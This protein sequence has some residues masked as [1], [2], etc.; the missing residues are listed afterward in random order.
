MLKPPQLSSRAALLLLILFVV[1]ATTALAQSPITVAQVLARVNQERVSRGMPPYALNAQLTSA[2]QTQANDMSR[3][4]KFGHIGSDGSTV[5]DRTARAGY[6]A[7]SWGRRIGEN[8]A[9]YHDLSE[10]M[11]FWMNSRPHR[12]NILHTVYREMG[13]GI[14]PVAEWGGTIFVL[15][16][17][18][19]PNVLPVFINDGAGQTD[20][21][22]VTLTL[23]NEDAYD[24]GNSIS[25]A[26]EVQISNDAKFAGAPWQPFSMHIP[27][28]LASGSGIQTVYVKYRDARGRTVV[29]SDSIVMVSVAF[30][31]PNNSQAA[32]SPS[33]TLTPAPKP[34][35][36]LTRRPTATVTRTLRPTA[37]RTVT[38]EPTPTETQAPMATATTIAEVLL[39][40]QPTELSAG[41]VALLLYDNVETPARPVAKVVPP[42]VQPSAIDPLSATVAMGALVLGIIA[43]IRHLAAHPPA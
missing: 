3:S 2:A 37:T 38:R 43:V 5:F 30:G 29:S 25:R 1:S 16:F 4:G 36:T 8:Y 19:E 9:A 7:Y 12:E 27:W 28:E 14:A 15:N 39:P 20:S 11:S 34:S 40:A 35:E 22:K 23:S 26:T 6:G 24:S 33:S 17:G 21:Q 41:G 10:A 32:P 31:A 18:S 42:L 13:V